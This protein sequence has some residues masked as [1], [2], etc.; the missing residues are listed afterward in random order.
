MSDIVC[1]SPM[2]Q[3]DYVVKTSQPKSKFLSEI[4]LGLG[5][6]DFV[7][8][9]ELWNYCVM[10]SRL[11][12]LWEDKRT[13]KR[14]LPVKFPNIELA[15]EDLEKKVGFYTVREWMR[16]GPPLF[17][18]AVW[19]YDVSHLGLRNFFGYDKA[20]RMIV[21]ARSLVWIKSRQ[22]EL[23]EKEEAIIE[24]VRYNA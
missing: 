6:R 3:E 7:D 16:T 24:M 4:S 14:D 10:T 15:K 17:S 9:S 11:P 13:P 19:D 5:D 8:D 23:T 1:F 22:G 2:P 20:F 21:M 12:F 18:Q